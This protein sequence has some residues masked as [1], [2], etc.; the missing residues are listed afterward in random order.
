MKKYIFVIL[1]S[2]VHISYANILLQSPKLLS[3]KDV[4]KMVDQ[5]STTFRWNFA[6]NWVK[7]SCTYEKQEA[8]IILHT[9]YLPIRSYNFPYLKN[10]K[11]FLQKFFPQKQTKTS[12]NYYFDEQLVKTRFNPQKIDSSTLFDLLINKKFIFYTGAG[13]SAASSVAT[14]S[15]LEESMYM[16][17]GILNFLKILIMEP[18]K[19]CFAF[20][21]FCKLCVDAQ[22]TPAH[23]ALHKIAQNKSCAIITENVDLLHQ[24]AGSLPFYANCS[25]IHA[26]TPEN[27]QDIDLII[28]VG[29]SYDDR[30]LLTYFK[31]HNPAIKFIAIDIGN[32]SYL[33]EQDYLVQEDLQ[34]VISK[35]SKVL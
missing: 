17:S 32:P 14:M 19:L 28:C 25:E 18:Q 15:Q 11:R 13:I 33:S 27:T 8:N 5:W 21:Q 26:I 1:I 22:P 24:R 20:K 6:K 3:N 30:G 12:P 9:G 16:G 7:F 35:L 4:Q 23:I 10:L 29:L 31:K 2:I 34:C